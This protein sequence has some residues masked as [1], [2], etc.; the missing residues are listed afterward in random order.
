MDTNSIDFLNFQLWLLKDISAALPYHVGLSKNACRKVVQWFWFFA[1]SAN[2]VATLISA[3]ARC[4]LQRKH[5]YF[6]NNIL[7]TKPQTD[8]YRWGKPICKW[9]WKTGSVIG[10]AL[11]MRRRYL[12]SNTNH[13]CR[14]ATMD[15]PPQ[16]Y[17][18]TKNH[19]FRQIECNI[20]LSYQPLTRI[21]R[22]TVVRS[23]RRHKRLNTY[24][25]QYATAV[26]ATKR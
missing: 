11:T 22:D 26:T 1:L 13:A 21:W 6:R 4:F 7:Q 5:L 20:P 23:C 8:R 24:H 3:E 14:D 16:I 9:S 2:S 10:S 17:K 18:L 19:G 12:I 25:N 15:T